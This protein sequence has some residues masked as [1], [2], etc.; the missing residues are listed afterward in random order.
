MCIRDRGLR[1]GHT[2]V[3]VICTAVHPLIGPTAGPPQENGGI[4]VGI[5]WAT[6]ADAPGVVH[7]LGN[8]TY[9][10]VDGV[11]LTPGDGLSPDLVTFQLSY[12]LVAQGVTVTESYVLNATDASITVTASAALRDSGNGTRMTRFGVGLPAFLFDGVSNSSV[13]VPAPTSQGGTATVTGAGWG[14]LAF[15]LPPPPGGHSYA[16]RYDNGTQ[17]VTR[18]GYAS[19]IDVEVSPVGTDAPSLTYTVSGSGQGV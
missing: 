12:F 11:V 8:Q 16:W 5:W 15:T 3:A 19:P 14:A 2:D 10:D 7:R 17:V 9:V 6:S 18:N 1:D 13:T 4:G